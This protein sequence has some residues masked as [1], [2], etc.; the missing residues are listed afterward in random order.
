MLEIANEKPNILDKEIGQ[1][2]DTIEEQN[3]PENELSSIVKDLDINTGQADHQL[4]KAQPKLIRS[5]SLSVQVVHFLALQ[6]WRSYSIKFGLKHVVCIC[7][8]MLGAQGSTPGV[9]DI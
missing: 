5:S 4:L 6:Q 3:I 2:V 1:P 7:P 9:F 8:C